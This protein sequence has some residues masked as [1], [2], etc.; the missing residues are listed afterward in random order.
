MNQLPA[1]VLMND[2][3]LD[4]ESDLKPILGTWVRPRYSVSTTSNNHIICCSITND[5][6]IMIEFNYYN[7]LLSEAVGS[8][9]NDDRITT[10]ENGTAAIE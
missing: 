8:S 10:E 4:L 5:N 6:D 1:K 9:D 7:D 3:I 2:Y